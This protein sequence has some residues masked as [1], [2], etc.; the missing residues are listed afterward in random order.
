L[1]CLPGWALVAAGAAV[2]RVGLGVHA[3]VVAAGA[4]LHAGRTAAAARPGVAGLPG[5]AGAAAGP[6]V[7]GVGL[8][9]GAGAV[10][11]GVRRPAAGPAAAARP[12]VAG[13]PGRAGTA[14]GPA[15]AGVGLGVGAGAVAAH[16]G[17]LT[18]GPAL[19]AITR[20]S[21]QISASIYAICG[22]AQDFPDWAYAVRVYAFSIVRA[23]VT[24]ATAVVMV[25]LQVA[26]KINALD[27][28]RRA[29][30]Q[31]EDALHSLS[32]TS[33]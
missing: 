17:R 26:A 23:P 11:A 21:E 20:V 28:P 24:A 32:G 5:R 16:L 22:F 6:A 2:I 30:A 9:V 31:A 15:V 18:C 12:G 19:S 29:V 1:A 25:S 33:G 13:L 8:G 14:A 10:A 7:A 4:G 3:L 27:Q